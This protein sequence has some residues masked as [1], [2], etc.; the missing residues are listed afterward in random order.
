MAV[1][2]TPLADVLREMSI[3]YGRKDIAEVALDLLE[4]QERH[5][6]LMRLLGFKT[7]N[8]LLL[9]D[10][11]IELGKT[12][13]PWAFVKAVVAIYPEIAINQVL[14]HAYKRLPRRLVF[15]DTEPEGVLLTTQVTY[16][17]LGLHGVKGTITLPERPQHGTT[18]RYWPE[19]DRD[20]EGYLLRVESIEYDCGP[21]RDPK[22]GQGLRC[23][24]VGRAQRPQEAL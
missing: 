13:S 10:L 5:A 20:A 21:G 23:S 12:H 15:D 19:D 8:P 6:V 24:V 7:L 18:L 22:A 16:N 9:D 11:V 3:L 2:P 14:E 4:Y 1:Y 17:L